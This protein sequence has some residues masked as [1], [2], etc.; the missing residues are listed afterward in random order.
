MVIYSHLTLQEDGKTIS[1]WDLQAQ[2]LSNR[3]R[4]SHPAAQ[5]DYTDD[6]G[7]YRNV[8]VG[9]DNGIGYY[10]FIDK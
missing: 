6:Q 2:V 3:V 9:G 7:A 5:V 4:T 10:G 1:A 8:Y